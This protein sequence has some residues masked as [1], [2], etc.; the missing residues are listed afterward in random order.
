MTKRLKSYIEQ[1]LSLL[2][3]KHISG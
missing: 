2:P 1:L 3:I